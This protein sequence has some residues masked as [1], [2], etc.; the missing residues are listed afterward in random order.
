MK[1]FVFG[2]EITDP[3]MGYDLLGTVETVIEDLPTPSEMLK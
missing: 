1:W 3:K 2:H